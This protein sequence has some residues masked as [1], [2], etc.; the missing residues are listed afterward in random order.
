VAGY[1]KF[2]LLGG[3]GGYMGVDGIN[4]ID[5][6]IGVGTSDRE[7]LKPVSIRTGKQSNPIW[8]LDSIIPDPDNYENSIIDAFIAFSP[9]SFKECSKFQ[10][11]VT[12]VGNS[13]QIDFNDKEKIPKSWGMLR[14]EAKPIFEKMTVFEA[15][16]S[17]LPSKYPKW[18]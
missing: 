14:E 5:L 7:W 4:P 8:K 1:V 2:Y 16:L 9:H 3:K 13:L 17:E 18:E 15:N 6:V 10:E 12:Q 11:V